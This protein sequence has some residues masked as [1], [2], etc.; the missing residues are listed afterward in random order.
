MASPETDQSVT[1]EVR[2]LR[3]GDM[4][5]ISVRNPLPPKEHVSGGH[6]IAIENIR[7]R[8][9]F[10]FGSRAQLLTNKDSKQFYA[11]LVVPYVEYSDR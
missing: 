9:V 2:G 5:Y 11:V 1:I 7:E 8:L 10:A 3:K 6:G 4:V